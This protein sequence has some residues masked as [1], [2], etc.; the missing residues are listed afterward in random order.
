MDIRYLQGY[1]FV[2]EKKPYPKE[3]CDVRTQY[4]IIFPLSSNQNCAAEG[5]CGSHRSSD[6][7]G[8][9]RALPTR[10]PRMRQEGI[11][12]SQLD[13]AQNSRSQHGHGQALGYMPVSQSILYPLPGRAHRGFATVSSVSAGNRPLSPLHLSTVPDDDRL[14]GGSAPW[15]ELEDSQRH[16]QILSGARLWPAGLERFAYFSRRR[17]LHPQGASL[18]DRRTG[19]SQRPGSLC[20]QRPQGQN[21]GALLQ[22]AKR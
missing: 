22:S 20:W 4:S 19:L 3:A 21:T 12:R 17:D 5:H 15:T 8:T 13:P 9:R 1:G 11:G 6:P 10:L 16:R 14:R 7:G 18:F 2:C